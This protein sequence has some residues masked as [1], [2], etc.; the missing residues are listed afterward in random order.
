MPRAAVLP[1]AEV[2]KGIWLWRAAY[3]GNKSPS[4]EAID[5]S[6][7]ER[8]G[9]ITGLSLSGMCGVSDKRGYFLSLH[10]GRLIGREKDQMEDYRGY[11]LSGGLVF[12]T[13]GKTSEKNEEKTAV[14]F[15]FGFGL[16]YR[17]YEYVDFLYPE[18]NEH[19]AGITPDTHC[20]MQVTVPFSNRIAFEH[21]L[22]LHGFFSATLTPG[23]GLVYRLTEKETGP[24]VAVDFVLNFCGMMDVVEPWAISVALIW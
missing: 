3:I 6:E 7:D 21:F 2:T 15:Y 12:E 1:S 8:K 9:S 24:A 11:S 23:V 20:G 17:E 10:G 19:R 22:D 4:F 14:S 13:R 5:E 16:S 18:D